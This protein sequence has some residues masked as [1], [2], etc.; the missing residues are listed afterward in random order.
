M[1]AITR[2]RAWMP[3]TLSSLQLVGCA[4][5][6]A[7]VVV[8]GHVYVRGRA[9][10]RIG[11]DVTLDGRR[12]PVELNAAPGG[13]I[14]VG[15]GARIEGGASLESA[16]HITLG[17]RVVV[18]GFAK[19]IDSPFHATTG[20]RHTFQPPKPVVVLDDSRIGW[21]SVLLPGARL[22]R[23]VTVGPSTI[24]SRVI[25]D[26]CTVFGVPARVVSKG[27]S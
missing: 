10:I 18:E 3:G 13:F 4:A 16:S 22:G 5:V 12:A 6:G 25:D 1:S 19:I 7:R 21:R 14:D 11:D 24:V 20:D 23:G 9:R 8:L 27:R 17:A 2:L 26:G 15:A